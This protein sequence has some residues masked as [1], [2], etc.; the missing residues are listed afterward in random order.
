MSLS[1][2]P[3]TSNGRFSRARGSHTPVTA[4]GNSKEK[5]VPIGSGESHWDKA[6]DNDHREREGRSRN[7]FS[8]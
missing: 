3:S 4:P 2:Q 7:S 1:P 5:E 8:T 6:K